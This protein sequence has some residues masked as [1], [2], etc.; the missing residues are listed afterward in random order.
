MHSPSYMQLSFGPPLVSCARMPFLVRFAL[1]LSL[2]QI[3]SPL[4]V[5]ANQ[6][7]SSLGTDLRDTPAQ[8]WSSD[9]GTFVSQTSNSGTLHLA[10][11][12]AS[13]N[14][15]KVTFSSGNSMQDKF[16]SL[17]SAEA[18]EWLFWSITVAAS[19][20]NTDWTLYCSNPC[21]ACT[22]SCGCGVTNSLD[23]PDGL[24]GASGDDLHFTPMTSHGK[25]TGSGDLWLGGAVASTG[26]AF[27]SIILMDDFYLYTSAF[28]SARVLQLFSSPASAVERANLVLLYRFHSTESRPPDQYSTPQAI[29]S[30]RTTVVWDL[31]GQDNHG[32]GSGW[33]IQVLSAGRKVSCDFSVGLFVSCKI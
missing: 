19:G 25:Y 33:S 21:L 23:R 8:T 7:A 28:S 11:G 20:T 6:T 2:T 9:T 24:V 27:S 14:T 31:S 4:P 12:F 22:G 18:G 16:Y 32:V 3:R 29:Y 13:S 26:G 17:A 15:L 10:V 1:Y 5:L 30:P